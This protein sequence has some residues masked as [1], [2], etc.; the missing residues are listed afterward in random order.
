MFM[1]TIA[2][3]P[4]EPAEFCVTG[5]AALAS[6]AMCCFLCHS[7]TVG[8]AVNW[9]FCKHDARFVNC[10]IGWRS[11]MVPRINMCI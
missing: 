4:F 10:D 9:D 5:G 11:D 8:V 2:V 3:G 6:V 7:E 1:N